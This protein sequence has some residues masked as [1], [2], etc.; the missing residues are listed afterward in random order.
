MPLILL[1][2]VFLIL[3]FTTLIETKQDTGTD[4]QTEIMIVIKSMF[5]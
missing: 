3:L 1:V 2:L 4:I 5:F